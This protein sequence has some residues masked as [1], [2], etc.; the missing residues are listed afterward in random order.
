[1]ENKIVYI[2]GAYKGQE[3]KYLLEEGY[4]IVAIE[5]NPYFCKLL[6][7]KFSKYISDGKVNIINKAIAEGDTTNLYLS[8]HEDWC[9]THKKIANRVEALDS[10]IQVECAN[11]QDIIN[12]HLIPYY[13][14][15]DIEGND[16]M[17]VGQ[18]KCKPLYISCESE[19]VGDGNDKKTEEEI[20]KVLYSLK[21]KGYTKFKI[22]SGYE[23]DI[24]SVV[25]EFTS[26]KWMSFEDCKKYLLT[27]SPKY[28]TF[29]FWKDILAT[30]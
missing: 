28:E 27:E 8:K 14:R 7:E 11:L 23:Y 19:C 29:T 9:S 17:A 26:D 13:L 25:E 10:I 18:L 24:K 16:A 21:N 5:A 6:K 22:V 3:F 20:L 1:M 2:V 30:Y 15:I 12:Q 4:S